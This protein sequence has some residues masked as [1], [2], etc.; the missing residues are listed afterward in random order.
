MKLINFPDTPKPAEDMTEAAR[1]L[2]AT[3]KAYVEAGFTR[4]QAMDIILCML[5]ASLTQA[6]GPNK[7]A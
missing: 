4:Q 5:R 1:G 3:Y 6:P 7:G 2:F